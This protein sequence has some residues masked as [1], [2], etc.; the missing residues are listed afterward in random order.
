MNV[1]RNIDRGKIQFDFLVGDNGGGKYD[2]EDEILNLG[3]KIYR[4][5]LKSRNPFKCFFQTVILVKKGNYKIVHR[6]S[7]NAIMC[8]D[9]IAAKLGGAKTL[10][11]HSHSSIVDSHLGRVINKIFRPLLNLVST[12]KFACSKKAGI[13]LF[14]K[15]MFTI[16]NNGIDLEQ[17]IYDKK[18][19]EVTRKK[20]HIENKFIIGHVGRFV[21]VKNH[22]FLID[23]LK[24]VKE[25]TP[26]VVLV[27]VGDGPLRQKIELKIKEFDLSDNVILLGV[28]TD[29]VDLLQAMDVFVFP[30]LYEGLPVTLVEAQAVG[31]PCVISDTI[32][33]EVSLT[34]LIHRIPL[35]QS[36]AEW[37]KEII[38]YKDILNRLNTHEDLKK[39]GYDIKYTVK[40]LEKLYLI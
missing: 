24:K 10:I 22:Y 26:N 11:A 13:W 23:I 29:I 38:K 9:L 39:A 31:L 34:T 4:V 25:L 17:F 8:I 37:A 35:N 1:Y 36:A 15:Q 14:G 19:R 21:Y 16:I 32:S 20:M 7:N 2:Y 12:Y 28:R 33:S 30:S 18:V 40:Y 5:T 3:G 6:H 27:L